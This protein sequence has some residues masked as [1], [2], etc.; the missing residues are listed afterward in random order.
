MAHQTPFFE[1][2][3]NKNGFMTANAAMRDTLSPKNRDSEAR[4]DLLGG[5]LN[6]SM[7]KFVAGSMRPERSGM[8]APGNEYL[9]SN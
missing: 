3:I 2:L 1:S 9:T 6:S 4:S 8:Q 5:S 7:S